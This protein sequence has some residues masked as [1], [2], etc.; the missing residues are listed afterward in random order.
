[1]LA[2]EAQLATGKTD[3][4]ARLLSDLSTQPPSDPSVLDLQSRV[5]RALFAS[6]KPSALALLTNTWKATPPAD[7]AFRSRL[8]EWMQHQARFQPGARQVLVS[9]WKVD[10]LSTAVL[11]KHFY[12]NLAAGQDSAEALRRAML[13]VRRVLNPHPAYWAAFTLAG[14]T[15]VQR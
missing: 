4:A 7:P 6:D 14:W 8:L 15:A 13:E 1:M 3:A 11:V 5:A 10:D 9:L 2:A 12:R